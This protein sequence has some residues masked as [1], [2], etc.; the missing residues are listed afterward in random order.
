MTDKMIEE[1]AE[2][3]YENR[4]YSDLWKEDALEIAEIFIKKGY[5]KIP[6]GSVV[7][8]KEEYEGKEIVVEMSGGHKLR[9]TV[10]KFGEMSRILEESTRKE[11]AKEIFQSLNHLIIKDKTTPL[12]VKETIKEIAKQYG[13]EE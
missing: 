2:T 10:G 5:R 6:E 1:M 12:W 13:V 7:L 8:S 3:L 11:T 9:L 4:P